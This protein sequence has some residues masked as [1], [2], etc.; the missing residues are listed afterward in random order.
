MAFLLSDQESKKGV[1]PSEKYMQHNLQSQESTLLSDATPRRAAPPTPRG[2]AVPSF[3]HLQTSWGMSLKHSNPEKTSL[4]NILGCD[5]TADVL[6]RKAES[7][8]INLKGKYRQEAEGKWR[9]KSR[10]R[11]S[12]WRRSWNGCGI[13]EALL[14]VRPVQAQKTSSSEMQSQRGCHFQAA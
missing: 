3:L 6:S 11:A 8:I 10:V 1:L 2:F 13:L 5:Q 12:P 7:R 14:P 4:E 9:E